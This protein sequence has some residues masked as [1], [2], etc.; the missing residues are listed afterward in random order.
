MRPFFRLVELPPDPEEIPVAPEPVVPASV[1]TEPS[2][3]D[4]LEAAKGHL[5]EFQ[6]LGPLPAPEDEQRSLEQ[7]WRLGQALS[8][9]KQ[10]HGHG[11]WL[12]FLSAQWPQLSNQNASR[13]L[14]F[15]RANPSPSPGEDSEQ[16]LPAN[17][18]PESIRRLRW[19]YVPAKER[20]PG[21]S[22]AHRGFVGAFRR[23]ERQLDCGKLGSQ[24]APVEILRQDCG[25]MLKH[26]ADLLGR[27][28]VRE[29]LADTTD[30]NKASG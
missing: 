3:A 26:L 12:A 24:P 2:P 18:R 1:V 14:L 9:L 11:R 17:F 20:P 29:L 30:D 16:T 25:P 4:Q 13:Y 28:Y 19:N 10:E 23:W 27:D 6:R 8:A 5:A 21:T 15:F 7:V 22:L